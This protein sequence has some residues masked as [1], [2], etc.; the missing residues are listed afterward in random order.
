MVTN[1][2][3]HHRGNTRRP[4][5][6]KTE[7]VF[8]SHPKRFVLLLLEALQSRN[9]WSLSKIKRV[10]FD[11]QD[12]SVQKVSKHSSSIRILLP[13]KRK[14]LIR[15]SHHE[16]ADKPLFPSDVEPEI[17][18]NFSGPMKTGKTSICGLVAHFDKFSKKIIVIE[19]LQLQ[20]A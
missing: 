20:R 8:I 5:E 7:K 18:V 6:S 9:V 13:D 17:R 16:K 3:G 2:R 1:F 4:V 11:L 12:V 14:N 15:V 19:K 10:H